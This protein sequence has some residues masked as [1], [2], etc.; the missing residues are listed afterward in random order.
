MRSLREVQINVTVRQHNF[1]FSEN[2]DTCSAKNDC[3]SS[4]LITRKK[5][6][7]FTKIYSLLYFGNYV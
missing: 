6:G 2:K 4:G 3:L 1:I 5:W 7:I